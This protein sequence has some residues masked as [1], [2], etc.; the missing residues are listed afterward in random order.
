MVFY[1]LDSVIRLLYVTWVR[2]SRWVFEM[3]TAAW[4]INNLWQLAFIEICKWF[5]QLISKKPFLGCNCNWGPVRNLGKAKSGLNC[6]KFSKWSLH[7]RRC[8]FKIKARLANHGIGSFW[9]K[10]KAKSGSSKSYKNILQIFHNY[11]S[12]S[13]VYVLDH[14]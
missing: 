14:N 1:R 13:F 3:V 4:A 10:G 7:H 12:S 11:V 2:W 6:S 5:L 8:Q 9:N